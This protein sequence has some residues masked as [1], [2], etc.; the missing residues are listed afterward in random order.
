MTGPELVAIV[1]AAFAAIWVAG[2][3]TRLGCVALLVTAEAIVVASGAASALVPGITW[4]GED[5]ALQAILM[6]YGLAV[7]IGWAGGAASGGAAR[8]VGT[9]IRRARSRGPAAAS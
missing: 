7:A 6:P 9:R 2:G 4:G 1:L 3:G 5:G 8:L